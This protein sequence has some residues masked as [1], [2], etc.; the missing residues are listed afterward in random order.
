[1]IIGERGISTESTYSYAASW[2]ARALDCL[3]NEL[4]E[5]LNA[6]PT[7]SSPGRSR[8]RYIEALQIVADFFR[9][10]GF[11]ASVANDFF[12][13][14]AALKELDMGCVRH[15]LAPAKRGRG[16]P[17]DPGDLW[18]ARSCLCTAVWFLCAEKGLKDLAAAAI[19]VD[20]IELRGDGF[21]NLFTSEL[22]SKTKKTRKFNP[23]M[24]LR[25]WYMEFQDGVGP[26]TAKSAIE[27]YKNRHIY[28]AHVFS[29]IIQAAGVPTDE[30]IIDE[31]IRDALVAAYQSADPETHAVVRRKFFETRP[32]KNTYKNN[33]V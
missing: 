32:R 31:I 17:P 20:R 25:R 16:A 27:E 5:V 22:C 10:Q 23:A 12:E 21:I 33:Q 8:G 28:I 1:M 14:V 18:R 9:E 2:E 7:E 29:E 30:R 11:D 13:L 24:T 4:R 19:V 26:V 3:N 6:V 15:A